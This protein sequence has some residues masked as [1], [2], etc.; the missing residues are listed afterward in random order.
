MPLTLPYLAW[1]H[2]LRPAASGGCRAWLLDL[3]P[4]REKAKILFF[5]TV[6]HKYGNVFFTP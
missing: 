4:C 1:G 5:N 3:K 2:N 6:V